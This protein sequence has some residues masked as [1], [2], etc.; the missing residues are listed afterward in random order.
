MEE[1]FALMMG[2]GAMG[3]LCFGICAGN[4]IEAYSNDK[5]SN[6]LSVLTAISALCFVIGLIGLLLTN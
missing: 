6:V 2:L 1:I 4:S 3:F 5:V